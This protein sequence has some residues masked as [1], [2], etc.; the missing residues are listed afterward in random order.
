MARDDH[1]DG[2]SAAADGLLTAG[3]LAIALARGVARQPLPDR[4]THPDGPEHVGADRSD[5]SELRGPFGTQGRPAH[6]LEAAPGDERGRTATSPGEIPPRGWLEVGKRVAAEAKADN[7]QLLAAGVAFYAMLAL[8][9]A[10][11]AVVSIYGLVVEPSQVEAQLTGLTSALPEEAADIL[12]TQIESLTEAES[13]TLGLSAAIGIAAALWGASSGMAHLLRALTLV[14]DEKENR[15]FVP[16][17]ALSLAFTVGATVGLVVILTLVAGAASLARS[18]GIGLSGQRI[19]TVVRW[20]VLALVMMVGLSILYRY[21]PNREDARWR[22]VTWGTVIGM[23]LWMVASAGFAVYVSVVG[24]NEQS[25]GALAGVI[26]LM[27]WL[28]LTVVAI[29]VGAEINAQLERQTV[30]DSTTGPEERPGERGAEVADDIR[31]PRSP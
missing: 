17:R 31:D 6:E 15:T 30:R 7:L 4:G 5:E 21:G 19:V 2:G 26:V 3:V 22:W 10:L 12:V 9:P 20:P 13:G 8:F 11:V 24:S 28:F 1:D 18:A 27:L 16:L 23:G 29:L 25:Y 14:Y